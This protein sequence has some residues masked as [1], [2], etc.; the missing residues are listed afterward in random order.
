MSQLPLITCSLELDRVFGCL[1]LHAYG[2]PVEV[3]GEINHGDGLHWRD[4][5][6]SHRE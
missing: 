4:C 2:V 1:M 6:R 3:C 5:L